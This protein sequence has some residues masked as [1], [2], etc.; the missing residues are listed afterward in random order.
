MVISHKYRY[1][2]IE[3]PMTGSTAVAEELVLNYE[4]VR[5]LRKHA[6]PF[7]LRKEGLILEDYFVFTNIR[8]PLVSIVSV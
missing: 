5:I 3:S 7:E 8:N 4:G 2:Y 1:I 6:L